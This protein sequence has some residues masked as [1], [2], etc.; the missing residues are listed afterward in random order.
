[1]SAKQFIE[2][3][4]ELSEK[5]TKGNWIADYDSQPDG[6]ALAWLGNW[7]LDTDAPKVNGSRYQSP[8]HDAQMLAFLANH[9]QAIIDLVKAAEGA[10]ALLQ[11]RADDFDGWSELHQGKAKQLLQDA[12]ASFEDKT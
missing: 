2:R 9:R 8:E 7:Y 11:K 1:M 3:L 6:H 12:L 4:E 10:R 5:A